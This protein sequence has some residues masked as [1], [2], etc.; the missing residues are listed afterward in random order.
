MEDIQKQL[1]RLPPEARKSFMVTWIK[2]HFARVLGANAEQIEADCSLMELGL[3]SL[4]AVELSGL[5]SRE[6]QISMSVMDVIQS[7]S[8]NNMAAR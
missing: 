1:E 3:D 8:I 6:L 5:M 2:E 4:M 7:G